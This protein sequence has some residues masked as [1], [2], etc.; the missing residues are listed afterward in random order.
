MIYSDGSTADVEVAD[1]MVSGFSSDTAGTKTITVTYGGM[2]CT[3]DVIVKSGSSSGGS[4]DGYYGGGGR[5][6][7]SDD[8]KNIISVSLEYRNIGRAEQPG[9]LEKVYDNDRY[10]F[11]TILESHSIGCWANLMKKSGNK[12]EFIAAAKVQRDGSVVLP[13]AEAD[14]YLLVV[15][16]YTYMPGDANDDLVVN[17]LDASAILKHIVGIAPLSDNKLPTLDCNG[18]GA[19]NALDASRILKMSVGLVA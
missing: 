3:F 14:K 10:I 16:K 7:N 17:A 13:Y 4:S 2:T 1:S 15:D 5:P 8:S 9:T 6:N 18:D 12:T 19:V 11:K